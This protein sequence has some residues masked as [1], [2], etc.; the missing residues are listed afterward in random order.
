MTDK[1][2]AHVVSTAVG[3][4]VVE[5]AAWEQVEAVEAEVAADLVTVTE[6]EKAMGGVV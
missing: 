2:M 6:V 4:A 5:V 3:M 1:V